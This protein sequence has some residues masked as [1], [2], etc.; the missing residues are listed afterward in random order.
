M[1]FL[2]IF[3]FKLKLCE[4]KPKFSRLL[5]AFKSNYT[6]KL[7]TNKAFPCFIK[8]FDVKKHSLLRS[9]S[10]GHF[11]G[12]LSLWM[13]STQMYELCR[14]NL[15]RPFT[16][17]QYIDICAICRQHQAPEPPI[18][19]IYK[20]WM[21]S[22][23]KLLELKPRVPGKLGPNNWGPN[24][25]RPPWKNEQLGPRHQLPNPKKKYRQKLKNHCPQ[26]QIIHPK[27]NVQ[28]LKHREPIPQKCIMKKTR[29]NRVCKTLMDSWW[30][31]SVL[32]LVKKVRGHVSMQSAMDS[33][34][35]FAIPLFI[36]EY[37]LFWAQW[38]NP[39]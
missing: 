12:N 32:V 11:K 17:Y 33:D 28:H 36:V 7:C 34:T 22:W 13:I 5:C 10:E 8:T 2:H 15:F 20:P 23:G 30:T 19:I 39:I 29:H 14:R 25:W 6:H 27:Y 38:W 21:S 35:D 24:V 16:G 3:N 18:L 37:I 1:F 4:F 31:P 9:I 26:Y